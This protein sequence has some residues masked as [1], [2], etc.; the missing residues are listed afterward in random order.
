M[1]NNYTLIDELNKLDEPGNPRTAGMSMIP[2]EVMYKYQKF[3]RNS[4]YKTPS[5]SG[6]LYFDNK[7]CNINKVSV[8]NN[9]YLKG[10]F[11]RY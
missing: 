6:M 9:G 2:E 5:E 3:I 10:N 8:N 11:N 1:N 7:V 4:T